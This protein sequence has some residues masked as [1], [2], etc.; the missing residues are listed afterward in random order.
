MKMQESG[1]SILALLAGRRTFEQKPDATG[2]VIK[3]KK[4]VRNTDTAGNVTFKPVVSFFAHAN[5]ITGTSSPWTFSS[6]L[7]LLYALSRLLP[8]WRRSS[9]TRGTETPYAATIFHRAALIKP[10]VSENTKAWRQ[11]LTCRSF[12]DFVAPVN[13]D[14][15]TF[16]DLLLLKFYL[17]HA[18]FPFGV[19]Y[20]S[21]LH[22]AKLRG[23]SCSVSTEDNLGLVL[24]RLKISDQNSQVRPIFGLVPS[25]GSVWLDN[26]LRVLHRTPRR[27]DIPKFKVW[28][29]RTQEMD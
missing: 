13:F 19:P 8:H 7:S 18:K 14:R 21:L 28:W 20:C 11:L 6:P 22:K 23:R 4:R 25:S 5:A 9:V 3:W 16:F 1:L 27:N 10:L 17:E 29:P 24:W 15:R 2:P 12:S 26:R